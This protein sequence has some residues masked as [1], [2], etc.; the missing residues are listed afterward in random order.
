MKAGYSA[1]EIVSESSRKVIKDK[2]LSRKNVIQQFKTKKVEADEHVIRRIDLKKYI[3]KTKIQN[4]KLPE[5]LEDEDDNR[6]ESSFTFVQ[7]AK[8]L[9]DLGDKKDK[10]EDFQSVQDDK[11]GILE[12]RLGKNGQQFTSQSTMDM[13]SRD[14]LFDH[15][16]MS[17]SLQQNKC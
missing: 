2:K 6:S 17:T 1:I 14:S 5:N 15:M 10:V 12:I 8:R 13:A 16:D 11:Q 3:S 9:P 4:L 7:S